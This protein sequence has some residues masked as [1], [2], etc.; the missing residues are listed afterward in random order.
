MGTYTAEELKAR[1]K[2]G[3]T[4]DGRDGMT[5]AVVMPAWK[6]VLSDEEIDALS[7]YLLS[8]AG[9]QPKSDW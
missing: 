2:S 3:V 6:D 7:A 4:P 8:L 9:S 1:I 5:P